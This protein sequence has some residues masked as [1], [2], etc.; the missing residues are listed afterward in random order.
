MEIAKKRKELERQEREV[1]SAKEKLNKRSDELDNKT[2]EELCKAN[3]EIPQ[4]ESSK[5]EAHVNTSEIQN[6]SRIKKYKNRSH[7]KLQLPAKDFTVNG[8]LERIRIPIFSGNKMDFQRWNAAVMSCVDLTSS[9]PQFKML[10]FEACLTGEAGDTIKGIGLLPKACEAAKA[11][12]L[13]KYSGS[14]RQVQSHLEELKKLKP[15]R[16]N[17]AKLELFADV[18]ERAVITLKENGSESDLEGGTLHKIILEKIPERLLRQYYRWLREKQQEESL[19][20]LKDWVSKEAEYQIQAAEIRNGISACP[21]VTTRKM[22]TERNA[23]SFFSSVNG[24]KNHRKCLVCA[25]LHPIWKCEAFKQLSNEDKWRIAKETGL[26]YR[27][28]G[29][30][31]LERS[32]PR[33]RQCD[34]KGCRE[35]HHY[36]L[37]FEGSPINQSRLRVDARPYLHPPTM[38]FSNRETANGAAL[39]TTEGNAAIRSVTMET[40][41]QQE[42]Q[43]EVALRTIPIILKNGN[44]RLLGQCLLDEGSDTT[45]VNE[46]VVEVLDLTSEKE[47]ITV[48]A[49]DKSISFMSG[50]FKIGLE[51]ADGRVDRE[52]TAQTSEQIFGG[53]KPVNW[54]KIKQNW[55][56]LRS[57]PFPKLATPNQIDV[58]L[59]AD[60]FELMYSM[61]EVMGHPNEPYARLYPLGWT[62]VG[63]VKALEETDSH[64]TGCHHTFR[65]QMEPNRIVSAENG[66][67]ELNRLLKRFWDL[68]SIGIVPTNLQLT[69]ENK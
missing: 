4:S 56:Q 60:H 58:L 36:L 23:R 17:N 27:C 33:S 37:H 68:E 28:L 8:Q 52:V 43:Q 22:R 35:T 48:I 63:K 6:P 2:D 45:Y 16:E 53:L 65:L 67:V 41:G 26:C 14:R 5:I 13:H 42:S 47:R 1:Q 20:T 64:Y 10:R 19:E 50:T 66:N 54:L 32:C 61:K 40:V 69:P 29:D 25:G 12:L 34:A 30:N 46:D 9:P 57:I 15:I 38:P 44:R 31:H 21:R 11:R 39:L 55:S 59:G 3:D 49:N 24:I 18:L 7:I 62:A 51:S